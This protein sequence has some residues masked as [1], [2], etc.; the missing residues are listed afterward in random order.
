MVAMQQNAFSLDRFLVTDDVSLSASGGTWTDYGLDRA[1]APFLSRL[2]VCGADP[3][4]FDAT[5]RPGWL[6]RYIMTTQFTWPLPDPI[7]QI[8]F[9]LIR[10]ADQAAEAYEDGRRELQAYIQTEPTT[11][12]Y[13]YSRA[14]GHFET[15]LAS[16]YQGWMHVRAFHREKLSL[17]EKG[18][19]SDVERLN[20]LYNAS[21]HADERLEAGEGA[22][23][24]TLLIWFTNAGL[25]SKKTA[26]EFKE[27]RKLVD[28][29]SRIANKVALGPQSV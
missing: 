16:T 2:H 18:D 26:L 1:F 4:E 25:E 3:L 10:R 11:R 27:L 9:G 6:S 28:Q 14:L 19:G 5:L 23:E 13:R 29:L 22:D 15:C 20:A 21:K 12:M 17:F 7:R 8:G 24:S